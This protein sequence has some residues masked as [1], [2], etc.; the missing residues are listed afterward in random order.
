MKGAEMKIFIS[1]DIEGISGIV[2]EEETFMGRS[3]YPAACRLMTREVNACV[4]G[5]LQGGA[6]EVVVNDCHF[7]GLNIDPEELNPAAKLIRG[8]PSPIMISGLDASFDALFLIGYHAKKGT[9]G[10]ILDHT[11]SSTLVDIRLNGQEIG[12]LG[13]AAGVAGEL[14]VPVALVSGDDKVEKEIHA[15]APTAEVVV[16]KKG[17]E[18][19]AAECRSPQLVRQEL[20]AKTGAALSRLDEMQLSLLEPPLRLDVSFLYTT[21]A[22]QAVNIPGVER[23]AGRSIVATLDSMVAAARLLHVLTHVG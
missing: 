12:E 18:R 7:H 2:S 1:A 6:T 17:M 19:T 3:L 8:Q 20:R 10:A 16:T 4:E 22:D 9:P 23:T 13:L 5:A 14:G 21:A 15:I 11:Y